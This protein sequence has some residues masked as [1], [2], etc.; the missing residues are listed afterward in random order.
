MDT[1]TYINA[2]RDIGPFG[3]RVWHSPAS[4]LMSITEIE[5]KGL[6]ICAN[7]YNGVFDKSDSMGFDVPVAFVVLDAFD[8]PGLPTVQQWFWSPHD[9]RNAIDFV[10]WVKPTID[11]KKWPT[12]V[13]CEFNLMIAYKRNFNHVFAT[14]KDIEK[15]VREA[16]SFDD[17]P[18]QAVLDKLTLLRQLVAE[19]R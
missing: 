5:Y 12:T 19:G 13:A 15:I 1:N 11:T 9:A 17:N 8:D 4:T 10:D 6:R 2:L 3:Y 14:L 16:I 18:S 7:R